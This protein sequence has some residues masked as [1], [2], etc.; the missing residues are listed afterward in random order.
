MFGSIALT[1]D[2]VIMLSIAARDACCTCC[3]TIRSGARTLSSSSSSISFAIPFAFAMITNRNLLNPKFDGYKFEAIDQEECVAHHSLQYPIT[4]ATVSTHHPL[5]FHEVQSRI[6]HN[7]LTIWQGSS[8]AIYV[9]ADY[10]VIVVSFDGTST[11]SFRSMFEMPRP[12]QSSNTQTRE[13]PSVATL[14]ST[15]VAVSDGAGLLYFLEDCGEEV[16]GTRGVYRLPASDP[17][18]IHIGKTL[19]DETVLVLS[20]RSPVSSRTE[21]VNFNIY[22]IRLQKSSEISRS[23]AVLPLDVIWQRRGSAVPFNVFYDES[24][25]TFVIMGECAYTVIEGPAVPAYEPAADEI[26]PIPR[27]NESLDVTPPPPYSWTQTSDSVTVV[28]PLPSSTPTACIQVTFSPHTLT[29]HI[30]DD[31]ATDMPLPHYSSKRLWGPVA[32]SSSMWTWDRE[33]DH[34]LGLLTLHLDKQHEG[35]RWSHLFESSGT[36]SDDPEVPETVDPS[37]LWKIR[38][39]LEKYTTSLHGGEDAS[40]LGLGTG[41]PSLA[42]GEMDDEVD[43]SIGKNTQLTWV[44]VNGASPSWASQSGELPG[45]LLST[46]LPGSNLICSLVLKNGIDGTVF[47]LQPALSNDEDPATWTH[48]STFSALSFVLASK[49]DTRFTHHISNSAVLAFE[50]GT[51]NRGGNVYIYRAAPA[52]QNWAKQAVLRAGNQGS[53]LGVG[54]IHVGN[55]VLILALTEKELVVVKNIV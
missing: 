30:K 36:S 2:S 6:T 12:L 1:I 23:D 26:V 27:A 7:H 44:K 50:N 14:S 34:H 5:S 11:P 42:Q 38:E 21:T 13:Y 43:L 52:G 41:L 54:A 37:E 33:G 3:V 20:A 55:D 4:Q 46:D 28:L 10:H 17:F 32:V 16:L 39:S 9:D 31:I 22:G 45:R 51:H 8:R 24:R 47:T 19:V 35:T 48:S 25:G 53:L 18:R 29:L 40:G 49:T 15:H